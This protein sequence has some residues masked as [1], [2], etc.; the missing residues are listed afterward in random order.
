[1]HGQ[2][3]RAQGYHPLADLIDEAE[4]AE[5]LDSVRS[6]ISSCADVM[7]THAAFIAEHCSARRG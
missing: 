1:M 7:P 6:V 5:Y 3:L 4:T 2:G